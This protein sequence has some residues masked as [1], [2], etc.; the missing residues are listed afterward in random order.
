MLCDW[1]GWFCAEASHHAAQS[2]PEIDGDAL[3]LAVVLVVG[4]LTMFKRK[5]G[6]K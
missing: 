4:V 1:L 6:T 3:C 5:D 2:A